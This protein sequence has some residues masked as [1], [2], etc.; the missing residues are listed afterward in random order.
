M[1]KSCIFCLLLSAGISS[2]RAQNASDSVKMAVARLF[3]AMKESD[4]KMLLACFTDSAILQTIAKDKTGE[5]F[6][7][8]EKL[9]DFAS[10][11]GSMP[12]NTADERNTVEVV[13][14]DGPLAIVWASY[15][16]Y[17]NGQFSHCGIN[18]FQLVRTNGNWKIQYLIDTRRK[19]GC[20]IPIR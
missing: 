5:I 13:K 14:V 19:Q 7:K 8:K 17:L 20:E 10:I 6:V 18:S 11:V 12:K 15:Q 1:L 9:A 2:A 3:T 16:F 4:S